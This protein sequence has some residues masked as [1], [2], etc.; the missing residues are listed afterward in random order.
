VEVSYYPLTING[1]VLPDL[2]GIQ[3]RV[4]AARRQGKDVDL[5]TLD[6]GLEREVIKR[7]NGAQLDREVPAG[8]LAY[9]LNGRRK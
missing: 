3:E 4:D 5:V 6:A 1:R 8:K 9:R 2:E 7:E